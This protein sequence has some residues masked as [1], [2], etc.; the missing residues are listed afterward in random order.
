MDF[1]IFFSLLPS[2]GWGGLREGVEY[3]REGIKQGAVEG[4]GSPPRD[5]PLIWM[6]LDFQA[7]V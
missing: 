3:L 2:M 7:L 4:V 6:N 5:S 1:C